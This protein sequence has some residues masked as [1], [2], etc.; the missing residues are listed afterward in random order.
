VPHPPQRERLI[1][2]EEVLGHLEQRSVPVAVEEHVYELGIAVVREQ[3][4]IA[5]PQRRLAEATLE[6]G[7]LVRGGVHTLEVARILQA[8]QEL[9]LPVLHR[10]ETARGLEL[11]PEREEVLRGH[12]L[13]H[14]DLF[15]EQ[16]LDDTH[17]PKQVTDTWDL[18]CQHRV[19]CR[20]ELEEQLLEPELV[21]LMDGDE[22][23]LVVG[24]GA[25]PLGRQQGLQSEV[26]AVVEPATFLPEGLAHSQPIDHIASRSRLL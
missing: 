23:Q 24:L 13:E 21:D 26:G 15:D 5:V 14:V 9:D 18:A 25:A 6:P 8:R 22:Q 3:R 16:A 10:L 20:L 11:R 12:R 2:I 19:A 7:L 1:V 4:E 17:S